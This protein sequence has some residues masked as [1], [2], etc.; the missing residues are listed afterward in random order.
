M[1]FNEN[2]LR[3]LVD[4]TLDT[5]RLG[6]LLTMAG[7]EVEECN[8]VA[9]A[10]SGV[11]I[12]QVLSV[13]KHPDA[14][15]LKLCRVD[16]GEPAP[17]QIVCGA[18]NV[19]AGMKVPCARVGARLPGGL[20]IKAARV[21]GVESFGMLCSARELGLSEDH[22]GLLALPG[23]APV[24]ADIR[25]HLELDDHVLLLKLTPNRADCL[26]VAGI[27]REVAALTGAALRLPTAAE[28][29][30]THGRQ[31]DIVLDAPEACP[32]FCGQVIS[33]LRA[34]APVPRWMRQRIER[35]GLRCINAV[36]DITN[37]VMLELGQPLHAY[38]D[39]KLSGAM[40][41]RYARDGET[42]ELLNG[43]I[44][45]LDGDALVIADEARVL[46]LAGIMGGEGSGVVDAT[47]DVFL[48][49]AF[50]VPQAIAG[51]ARSFG[52]ASDAS[53]RFERGVDFGNTRSA[54]SRATAL[55]L[56]ICG[57]SA[58]PLVEAVA[59]A[60]LPQRAPVR[61][62]CS[63]AAQVLGMEIEPAEI[64]RIFTALGFDFE[65][66]GADF[67]VTPPS[68]RFDIEI[69]E[70]L[71]EEIVRVRGYDT[72]PTP[73]PR[74]PLRM[75]PLTEMRRTPWQ[76]RHILASLDYQ[77]VVNFSFVDAGWERDFCASEAPIVLANPIASQMGVMRSSL[78]GGLVANLASNLKRQV[79]RVRVFEL[80]RC[81]LRDAG[82]V[83]DQRAVQGYAQPLRVAALAA[84]L[85]APEQWGAEKRQVD[86]Y[87]IKADLEALFAPRAVR[88]EAALHPALHP[89]RSAAVIRDGKRVGVLGELH[90]RWTQKYA[91]ET[92]PVLFELDVDAA[93][94]A[95]L[96]DYR[97][98]S[99]F[100]AVVRDIAL[101][102]AA[103]LPVQVLL[104]G[105]RGAAPEIV[106]GL[107]V[108]DVYQ[109]KGIEPDR[110]SLAIRVVMQDT[111]RTLAEDEVEAARS[112][113]IRFA[114]E[115]FSARLRA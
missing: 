61:L 67:L 35:A 37:Y 72:V 94:A 10:F 113:L 81:F 63:R 62:R 87:D 111:E 3:A 32:R 51:K 18:P 8:P 110:K 107:E 52:F 20:K 54:M 104:D 102:V 55:I 97:E 1:R 46:G 84:G 45:A 71:I 49:A 22:G 109:G 82:A 2:W 95:G 11:V 59:A 5:A 28:P 66:S 38:D 13:E 68:R 114:E 39:T 26:S 47:T 27:A 75:L 53:H 44:L 60:H 80:G 98:P 70:D 78:I 112:R 9:P 21:R 73:P 83:A 33:G 56:E 43:Q 115:S 58:G 101:V 17:L 90:P 40:H 48:E 108:F 79:E 89:G 65:R 41:A 91:L 99:R 69:E 96:P 77:E 93:L 24:G 100:P 6:D 64:A 16:A 86:F 42:L 88:F 57:G 15:K 106:C 76:V 31:R 25:D 50:F 74:G 92:S 7:L 34:D 85:A 19:A 12:A 105:M 4:T 14:D 23:D 29:A 36:V 30:A 103:D